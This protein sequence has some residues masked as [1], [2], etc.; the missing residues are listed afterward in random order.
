MA[1][2]EHGFGRMAEPEE[3]LAAIEG[4]FERSGLMSGR[5]ALV[6]SG[7]THEPIDPVRFIGNRS[8]GKQGHAIAT[9]LAQLG[10]QTTL[11]SGP[12]H[13]P[14]PAGVSVVHV[15]TAEQMLSAC[16]AALPV[17]VAVCAAAVGDW[18][19]K[20]PAARKIKKT[21][22]KPPAFA[23]IENPDILASLAAAGNQRPRLVV[24]FAAETDKVVAHA[25]AKLK[26]KGCDWIETDLQLSRDQSVLAFHDDTL[27]RL[28]DQRGPVE[29]FDLA[30]LQRTRV[31]VGRFPDQADTHI[32]SISRPLTSSRAATSL[33]VPSRNCSEAIILSALGSNSLDT[34][35]SISSH[36]VPGAWRPLGRYGMSPGMCSEQICLAAAMFGLGTS[37]S[38]E[39]LPRRAGSSMS[40]RLVDAMTATSLRCMPSISASRVPRK[41]SSWKPDTCPRV[42]PIASISSKK[43]IP[44][45]S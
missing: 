25:K 23:M 45:P 22:G 14:D 32:C 34:P 26:A 11:V 41:R 39:N 18:R 21:K 35:I 31:L 12:T 4:F 40:A 33:R 24:G 9:A 36:R 19:A 17:H 13:L 20:T 1:C 15:E 37:I 29:S 2:G 30:E 43:A 10:A 28:T 6:T 44:G 3:L 16:R 8:S 27:N 5:R 7:P 38:H 42:L